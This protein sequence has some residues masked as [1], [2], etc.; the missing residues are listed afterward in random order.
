MINL[1]SK[2]IAI[3]TETTGLNP[4]D[5]F[6]PARPFAFS[7]YDSKGNS[8]Y[9]RYH[10]DPKTREVL[11]SKDFI[12]EGSLLNTPVYRIQ[13]ILSSPAE[14]VFFNANFDI[15]MLEK[16]GF[17]VSG[18]I[19]DA[20]VLMH[21]V[22]G[23][24][25]I[26]YGLKPLSKKYLGIED[27]DQKA[28]VTSVN[29]GRREAKKRAWCLSK[30]SNKEDYWLAD[31]KLCEKYAVR[32]AKRTMVMFLTAKEKIQTEPRLVE[33]YKREMTLMPIVKKMEDTGVRVFKKDLVRLGS[34]YKDYMKEQK[35]VAEKEGGKNLNFKSPQQL[36]KIFYK[37]RGHRITKFT[38]KGNPKIDGVILQKFA[39]TDPLAKAILEYR[40]ASH[41]ITG[42]IE[43]YNRF[44]VKESKGTWVLHTNYRQTGPKTGR[45]AA[46]DPNLMQVA[47]S[48]GVKNKA[49]ITLRPRECF[50]PRKKHVWYLP[51]FSQMEV[52][53]FAFLAKEKFMMETL[54]SGKD[55]HG[56]MAK[57]AYGD[58]PDFEKNYE[59]HRARAKF[60]TW[61]KLYGGGIN[62][63]AEQLL[64]TPEQAK[65]YSDAYDSGFPGLKRYIQ[66][67]SELAESQGWVQNPYGRKYIIDPHFGYKAVN[68]MIQGTCADIMKTAM[69]NVD[70]VLNEGIGNMLLTLHD[71]LVIEIPKRINCKT[72]KQDITKAMQKSHSEVLGIPVPLPVDMAIVTRRWSE[73]VK[74]CRIHF[75][76]GCKLC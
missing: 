13:E 48:K 10:V 52:W 9:H 14:K 69:I 64:I 50:G 16:S 56:A 22:T 66:K 54:L 23:G 21:I 55:I 65:V 25:E 63:I 26:V 35:L 74:L 75:K 2:Y 57:Q 8:E 37:D 58:M 46:G 20:L 49:D 61:C 53:T 36:V 51:D 19:H 5:R 30:R 31:P 68:Y 39:K 4:W 73:P 71:E 18:K 12:K 62:A 76:E 41:A 40:A 17:V 34:F 11:P 7:F 44:R 6:Y 45:F 72:L 42:F 3:D 60:M 28:L 1:N 67:T 32:D 43:P 24:A 15:R 29:K 33:V 38:P 27:D 47:D 70:E 59:S